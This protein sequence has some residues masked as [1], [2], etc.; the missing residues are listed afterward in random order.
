MM[1]MTSFSTNS[2]AAWRTSFSRSEEHTSEL[3]SRLHLVCRLLLGKKK[4]RCAGAR[5]EC[6]GGDP[7]VMLLRS[8]SAARR[9]AF[10]VRFR[11]ADD[12]APDRAPRQGSVPEQPFRS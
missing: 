8:R 2:R 7:D 1:G 3:Q 12:P 9:W 6:W 5:R 11:R 4:V 10:G